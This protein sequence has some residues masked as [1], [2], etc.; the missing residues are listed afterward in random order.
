[1][2]KEK[3]PCHYDDATLIAILSRS[4]RVVS[5]YAMRWS[6]DPLSRINSYIHTY[7]AFEIFL[8][9]IYKYNTYVIVKLCEIYD[10]IYVFKKF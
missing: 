1:M 5:G 8:L 9:H 2:R 3:F 4:S 6:V 7:M 10:V